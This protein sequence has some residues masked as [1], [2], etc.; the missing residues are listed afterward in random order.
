LNER[1]C[2]KCGKKTNGNETGPSYNDDLTRRLERIEVEKKMGEEKQQNSPPPRDYIYRQPEVDNY[3]DPRGMN[4]TP[5]FNANVRAN[6]AVHMYPSTGSRV[7]AYLIDMIIIFFIVEL[8]IP[9]FIQ[10]ITIPDL[11][12]LP[13][14]PNSWTPDDEA[15]LDQAVVVLTNIIT[16]YSILV[17]LVVFLYNFLFHISPARAT[18]GQL[19]LR[20]KLADAETMAKV[21]PGKIIILCVLKC[22]FILLVFDVLIGAGR[23]ELGMARMSNGL[24]RT[25]MIRNQYLDINQ[26]PQGNNPL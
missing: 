8:L 20:F 3:L 18:I 10:N 22:I 15:M 1:F 5:G 9:L 19:L 25:V 16:I 12:S 14:D 2:P 17:S 6:R 4:Q 11:T 7:L 21:S 13:Q 23:R 26:N 24:T